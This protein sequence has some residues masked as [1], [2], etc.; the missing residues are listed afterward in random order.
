MPLNHIICPS[1]KKF[2]LITVTHNH[3][4]EDDSRIP[5]KHVMV[6]VETQVSR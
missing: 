6:T 1:N 2:V 5:Q 4:D 3:K